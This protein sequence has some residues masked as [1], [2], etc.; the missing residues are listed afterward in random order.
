MTGTAPAVQSC[1]HG[2]PIYGD[3]Q[4]EVTK[5]GAEYMCLLG[6]A[7]AKSCRMDINYDCHQRE[8]TKTGKEKACTRGVAPARRRR[9][10]AMTVVGTV[11]TTIRWGTGALPSQAT[12]KQQ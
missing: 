2:N 8:T 6:S 4:I 11:L 5:T 7:L 1:G 10:I 3:H 12:C 9:P